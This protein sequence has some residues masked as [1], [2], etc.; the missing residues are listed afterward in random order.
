MRLRGL[1]S[2]L[3]R[4]YPDFKID[5]EQELAYYRSIR[6]EILSMTTDTIQYTNTALKQGK[7]VL[8][9][10]ANATSEFPTSVLRVSSRPLAVLHDTNVTSLHS[11]SLHSLLRLC[12]D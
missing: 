2:Q 10:G 7:K 11:T 6:E 8:I 3:E 5:V 1:V 12:S 9:E 4:S